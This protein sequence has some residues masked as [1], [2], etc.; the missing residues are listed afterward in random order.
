[1]KNFGFHFY[2]RT[3]C[4]IFAVFI[5]NEYHHMTFFSDILKQTNAYAM[6]LGGLF[7]VYWCVGLLCFVAGYQIPALHT[8]YAFILLSIPVVGILLARYFERQVRA[9][10]PVDFARGFLY[11]FMMYLYATAFLAGV[12]YIYFSMF[13]NGS[14]IE[15]NIARFHN[16]DMQQLLNTP[17]L[18]QQID[19]ALAAT[20][21]ANMDELLRSITPLMIAANIVDINM[22]LAL[23]LSLP[24]AL[25]IK[26]RSIYRQQ[27]RTL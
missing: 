15:A 26:T 4:R 6:Q 22:I 24:T 1:M 20:G 25:I 3:T 13:D 2:L 8:L 10:A 16:P 19:E 27:K 11:S 9:D 14:F 12:A 23:I 5:N 21:Y 7:G 18:K 17:Q